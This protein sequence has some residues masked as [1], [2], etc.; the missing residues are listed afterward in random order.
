MSTCSSG[1]GLYR[2]PD[3]VDVWWGNSGRHDL[4]SLLPAMRQGG[5]V[6]LMSGITTERLL[7]VGVA[8]THDISLLG[9][10]RTFPLDEAADAHRALET[11]AFRGRIVIVP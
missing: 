3:G 8:Y 7:P 11:G 5:R 10:G 1:R 2:L 6:I 9:V 4:V